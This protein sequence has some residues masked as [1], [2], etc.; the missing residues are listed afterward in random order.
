MAELNQL[1]KEIKR[2][3]HEQPH[4]PFAVVSSYREQCILNT[5]VIKPLLVFVLSGTKYLGGKNPVACRSGEFIFLSNT[6]VIDIRNV[7]EME[8]FALLI[9]F[10]FADF[11]HIMNRNQSSK[12]SYFSGKIT[13]NLEKALD[14][15]I[16]MPSYAPPEIWPCRRQ[17]LLHLFYH[18]GYEQVA[19]IAEHPSLSHRIH[20]L[21][22]QDLQ[23]SWSLK[24][25]ASILSMSEPTLRRKLS[26]E[27]IGIK[28][29]TERAKLG[30]GLN[31]IQCTNDSIGLIADRCGF[32]S[33]SKFTNRFKAIFGV[34]PSELRKTR[35][36]N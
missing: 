29:I 30:N 25:V 10:D 31:L 26:N 24:K 5:P 18:L 12:K 11:S 34:T 17:E 3:L 8:Y 35:L 9:E 16:Q 6:P 13:A 22:L 14:Q 32:S 19:S 27:G 36:R 33:Q 21:V 7:P 4:L 2:Q 15:F 23:S 1:I 28:S 20:N